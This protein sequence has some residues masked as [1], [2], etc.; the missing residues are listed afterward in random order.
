MCL[1]LR[2]LELW[3]PHREAEL[4]WGEEAAC[5]GAI[6]G[7]GSLHPGKCGGGGTAIWKEKSPPRIDFR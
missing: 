3:L 7:R 6:T 5:P 2:C 4:S 1:R